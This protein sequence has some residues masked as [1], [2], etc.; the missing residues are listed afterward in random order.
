MTLWGEICQECKQEWEK[1]R[2]S[3]D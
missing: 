2:N 1:R 3:L